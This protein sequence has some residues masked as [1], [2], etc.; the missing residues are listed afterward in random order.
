MDVQSRIFEPFYSTK[1]V[2]RGSGMGLSMVHGIVHRHDGHILLESI[3]GQST[4]FRI[5]LKR[6]EHQSEAVSGDNTG[7]VSA[8]SDL[9]GSVLLVDDEPAVSEFMQDLLE[10]WGLG[11]TVFNDS[12]EANRHY[13]EFA[14]N[15]PLVI[16]DLTM[17]RMSGLELAEAL[18]KL[19]PHQ[20]I[21][22]YTGYDAD[23]SEEQVRKL[24]IRALVKKPVDTFSLRELVGNLIR[25]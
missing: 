8:G 23:I 15:Y 14:D 16:L 24:G 5:L 25:H 18:L 20:A 11:V 3:E 2:G 7:P 17:P 6:Y 22:L 1:E 21:I 12:V 19:R 9:Q 13:A 10:S 4:C